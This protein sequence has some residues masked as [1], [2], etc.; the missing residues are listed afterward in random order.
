MNP[1]STSGRGPARVVLVAP[2]ALGREL[3]RRAMVFVAA[4][5][6]ALAAVP[7]RAL[8]LDF[9]VDASIGSDSRSP[10]QAQSPATPWR[11]LGRALATVSTG[12]RVV[13]HPGNYAESSE[14]RF[15][16]VEIRTD[17]PPGAVVFAVPSGTTGLS[18]RHPDIV[19]SGIVFRGGVHAIRADGAPRLVVRGC[20]AVGQTANGFTVV[21]SADARIESSIA[22]SAAS[23]GIL[24]TSSPRSYLRNNLVYLAGEW[25]IDLDS[26][27]AGTVQPPVSAGNVVA[28]NTVVSNGLAGFS[29]SGGLRLK[30]ATGE[31]RDNLLSGNFPVGVRLDTPGSVVNHLLVFG[32]AKPVL[33]LGYPLGAGMQYANPRFVDPDGA[34][35]VLGGDGWADDDFSLLQVDA[36]QDA[37]SPAVD[38]GSGGVVPRDISGSTRTDLVE[39]TGAA[40]LG[41]HR[42]AAPSAGVPDLGAPSPNLWVNCQSGDDSITRPRDVSHA[43]PLRTI[44]R[45]LSLSREGDRIYVQPGTCNERVTIDLLSI[46]LEAE[47]PGETAIVA[48]AGQSALRVRA[49]RV[50]VAGFEIVSAKEGVVVAARNSSDRL[51]LVRLRGL[52]VGP[53]PG[54]RIATNGIRLAA[55]DRARVETCRVTGADQQGI[56]VRNGQRS[57]V[58]NNL[59]V[60]SGEWG[61]HLDN[62]DGA[63][64][65][66]TRNV[67]L[68]NTAYGN[69]RAAAGSGGIRLRKASGEVA[70]NIVASNLGPGIRVD[71]TPTWVHH[72][73][74][75]GNVSAIDWDDAAPPLTW[76]QLSSEPGF[77]DPAAGD[78]T[79][80]H[81]AAGQGGTSAAVDAAG[82]TVARRKIVGST[83]IDGVADTGDADLGHHAT[84]RILRRPAPV[85][86]PTAP[87][88]RTLWVDAALGNDTRSAIAAEDPATPWRT[89]QRAFGS[90]GLADGDTLVVRAGTYT[91]GFLVDRPGVRLRGE[92]MPT[93][94]ATGPGSTN[95]RVGA[96]RVE[97]SG[98]RL[99]GGLRGLLAQG[100]D[101]LVLRDLEVSGHAQA[102]IEIEG[103]SGVLAERVSVAGG[104][105]GLRAEN[106][107]GLV[108]RGIRANGPSAN[109]LFLVAADEAVVDSNR[110]VDAG[111]Q[112]ILVKRSQ[113]SYVRN[114]AVIRSG[115]WGI[116]VDDGDAPL[117]ASLDGHVVAFNTVYLAGGSP[118]TTTGGIRF[119]NA[120]GEIR[121]NVIVAVAGA[122]VRTELA[123]TMVHHNVLGGGTT[124]I[125]SVA[126]QNPRVWGNVTSDPM[127]VDSDEPDLS[128]SEVEAGQA[129]TSPA[130]DAGSGPIGTR[131][132]GGSTRSDGVPD[133]GTANIG[134]HAGA[135]PTAGE[136]PPIAAA[137]SGAGEGVD[138]WVDPA[139]GDDERG[140][141]EAQSPT[142]P[143]K[144][145]A[146][147]MFGAQPGD[148]VRVRPGIYEEAVEVAADAVTLR[149][150]GPPG[151]VVVRPP[152][153]S[154]GV[155]V[156]GRIDVRIESLV[157]EGGSQGV[158][159]AEA[160]GIRIRGVIVVLPDTVGIQVRDTSGLTV[161]SCT[162]TGAG[163][164]GLLVRHSENAYLRNN[165]LYLNAEW[166]LSLEDTGDPLPPTLGGHVVAF[167]TVH[168]NESGIRVLNA[169]GEIRDNLLTSQV[170]LGMFLA[171]PS[172]AVHHNA[173]SANGRDRDQSSAYVD[174]I[175]VWATLGGNPRY[176]DPAGGDGILGLDGWQDDDFRLRQLPGQTPASPMVDA[177]SGPVSG[178]DIDGSTRTDGVADGGIADLG[179]HRGASTAAETPPPP[180]PVPL[181]ETYYVGPAG[182][183][184][185]TAATA[186]SP[187]TP[188]RT[189]TRAFQRVAR[190]DTIVVLPGLYE[191]SVQANVAG[192][193][194]AAD[195]ARTAIVRPPSGN[196]LA[197]ESEDVT[198]FGIV[199]E[200]AP[201]SGISV[202]SGANR[203]TVRACVVVGSAFQGVSAQGVDG[204]LVEDTIVVSSAYSG[205]TLRDTSHATVR[206]VLAYANGEWGVSIRNGGGTAGGA[207]NVVERSTL[208]HNRSGNLRLVS[209]TIA[210][211]RDNLFT[212]TNGIGLRLDTA[213]SQLLA[214]GFFACKR[215]VDPDTYI[216]NQCLACGQNL[217]RDPKFVDPAGADGVL[218]GAGWRDDDFRLSQVAAGQPVQSEAVD[219]GSVL[220]EAIGPVGSTATD[221]SPDSGRLDLGFHVVD[222]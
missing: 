192:V 211:V 43:R 6:F 98:L 197:V 71:S 142:T 72:N 218:G 183:D 86:V 78:F 138:L 174:T 93:I 143:W 141:G 82:D 36:G 49:N 99:A 114:N 202:L 160:D 76:D 147:A 52:L 139:S 200:N 70:Y 121:D 89:I 28:F 193:T 175:R 80:R 103:S 60:D 63:P 37:D 176:L 21:G 140:W 34:D 85:E 220:V 152:G 206:N 189:I 7:G 33:P 119:Q 159:A 170:D 46:V 117:P 39:D 161:D 107:P 94:E 101:S 116:H 185:R 75:H 188:W 157:V 48:P 61:I 212:D 177:G 151:S 194:L 24:V 59:V 66:T 145:L 83:R 54:G 8:A 214:N 45:A 62:G 105:H 131:D 22:V 55:V 87:R 178:L 125:D 191:E 77:T 182:D 102:G 109:G 73:L 221:G 173:F 12:H 158:L 27:V 118:A 190:G 96:E 136:P 216:L 128:L 163:S 67:V 81:A 69:G 16:G 57:W 4:A 100:A 65:N 91:G 167:N 5:A 186:K 108:V 3:R 203:A 134:F 18:V 112:G 195:V 168:A 207:E 199:V 148:V 17:G 35:G 38:A 23:R 97:V 79:L 84:T 29:G 19:V 205:I 187:G 181:H 204:L 90:G 217:V 153:G 172:L 104:T 208:A 25:G 106:A 135:V 162:V 150:E 10:L 95:L 44:A 127:L 198:I 20:S 196:G 149:G 53:P 179:V 146:R 156:N 13:L 9:H 155:Y 88:P 111:G 110:V 92:S 133:A 154:P 129:A 115:E 51:A 1:I 58:R 32:S 209:A 50:T 171:G 56:V 30:N 123:P 15:A 215:E 120:S 210:T 165:L 130:V 164:H 124:R 11:T 137:M 219:V 47:V 169:S 144:S 180:A 201:A 184:S 14:T 68:F 40:D 41:W 166:G 222:P 26:S 31:V 113:R 74:A 213:G 2:T 132:I 64:V 42:A 126:G 122:V